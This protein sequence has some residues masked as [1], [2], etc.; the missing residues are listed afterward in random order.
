MTLETSQLLTLTLVSLEGL[1]SAYEHRTTPE[2]RKISLYRCVANA[3]RLLKHHFDGPF[4]IFKHTFRNP[5][6]YEHP[7]HHQK[8]N[9]GNVFTKR[10]QIHAINEPIPE[11]TFES[12]EEARTNN[13]FASIINENE[14]HKSS[15]SSSRASSTHHVTGGPTSPASQNH[16]INI[17]PIDHVE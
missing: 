4:N 14:V 10:K 13:D 15:N 17:Q 8:S 9:H 7:E 2:H 12:D 11:A 6:F 1:A 3:Y 16:T 5:V